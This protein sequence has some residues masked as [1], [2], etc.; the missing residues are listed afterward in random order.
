[1][2]LSG[3][4]FEFS[5]QLPFGNKLASDDFVAGSESATITFIYITA[6]ISGDVLSIVFPSGAVF[7]P[8]SVFN[9]LVISDRN[10][11]A[12]AIGGYTIISNPQ[13]YD[14]S[15]ITYDTENIFMNCAGITMTGSFSLRM[16]LVP[17]DLLL[18]T[19]A[20]LENTSGAV[21]G[22]LT[23]TD[24]NDADTHTLVVSDDRFEIV[25]GSLKLKDGVALDFDIDKSIDVLVTAT[26]SYGL[27]YEETLSIA[28]SDVVETFVATR[29]NNRLEGTSGADILRGR[30]GDDVLLG[31]DGD[32]D[33]RSVNGN[34]R[35]RGGAGADLFTFS[36]GSDRDTIMDFET[37]ID[38]IDIS[39][40]NAID[41]FADLRSHA[42]NKS[43]DL[44][45]SAG[46]DTLI[47]KDFARADL[48][49]T[50]FVIQIVS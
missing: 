31:M 23:V 12:P 20:V 6:E 3:I 33:L 35:M 37:G 28:V 30:Q 34:D 46:E 41:D 24:L 43:G 13:S 5:F 8:D 17:S 40:W 7:D 36:T 11:A 27:E 39:R 16:E 38:T 45:I 44:W 2:S 48:D 22:A 10:N 1:M 21:V 26:D 50:D 14:V 19:S 9:G 42:R 4:T 32:D 29:K 47:L 15:N 49:A 18:S 25:A